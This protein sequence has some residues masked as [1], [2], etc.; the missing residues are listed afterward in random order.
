MKELF[1][2]AWKGDTEYVDKILSPRSDVNI[3]LPGFVRDIRGATLPHVL[4]AGMHICSKIPVWDDRVEIERLIDAHRLYM[5]SVD[6][7]G[8]ITLSRIPEPQM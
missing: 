1:T 4:F 8:R 2:E 3:S 6:C 7:K 5:N